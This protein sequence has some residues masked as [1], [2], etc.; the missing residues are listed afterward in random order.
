[1]FYNRSLNFQAEKAAHRFD[2]RFAVERFNTQ[3]SCVQ[4]ISDL[5]FKA[6]STP[7]FVTLCHLSLPWEK[8]F[9]QC[10]LKHPSYQTLSGEVLRSTNLRRSL[11]WLSC[12][13]VS[14]TLWIKKTNKKT[15]S[16]LKNKSVTSKPLVDT[17]AMRP[18]WAGVVLKDTAGVSTV[19]YT[20]WPFNLS[21]PVYSPAQHAWQ[22]N[23]LMNRV[24]L[25]IQKHF[26]SL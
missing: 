9:V 10:Q 1:M 8:C 6:V 15:P 14:L 22:I 18:G 4:P 2:V 16:G 25:N 17:F 24:Q 19:F 12:V 21:Q 7:L 3:R 23:H 11:R 5:L 26:V 20:H 13:I